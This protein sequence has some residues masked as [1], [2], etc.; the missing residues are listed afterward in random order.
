MTKRH[1]KNTA[2]QPCDELNHD[3]FY[4]C[5]MKNITDYVGCDIPWM[6]INSVNKTECNVEQLSALKSRTQFPL[7]SS[8][9]DTFRS[10]G[11]LTP[12]TYYE[13][14]VEMSEVADRASEMNG[15]AFVA[16]YSLSYKIPVYTQVFDYTGSDFIADAGGYLGLLLGTSALSIYR[17]MSYV[18]STFQLNKQKIKYPT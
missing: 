6:R 17:E 13:Y 12:C 4:D 8:N 10:S 16:F 11:C 18:L 7:R 2:E 1:N 14:F 3:G 5:L 15:T 9:A